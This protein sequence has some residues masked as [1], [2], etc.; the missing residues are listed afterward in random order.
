MPAN[1]AFLADGLGAMPTEQIVT[2]E[3]APAA[4]WFTLSDKTYDL[5]YSHDWTGS[6]GRLHHISVAHRPRGLERRDHVH[7]ARCRRRGAHPFRRPWAAAFA[8]ALN[9]LGGN[10]TVIDGRPGDAAVCKLVRSVYYKGMSAAIIEA[11][12]AAEAVG[13]GDWLRDMIRRDMH[14]FDIATLDR[15]EDGTRRHARRRAAEMDAATELL[16]TLGVHTDVTQ[17]AAHGLRRLAVG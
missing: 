11:I 10:V 13:V 2:D 4:V 6:T 9:P 7:G 16:T 17:A 12:A 8:E 3:G 5:V 15:I 1:A 14:G